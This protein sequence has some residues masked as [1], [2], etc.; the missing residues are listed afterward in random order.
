MRVAVIV[1]FVL[2]LFAG[3]CKK[4]TTPAR[5]YCYK[6]DQKFWRYPANGTP[7]DSM[8]F[9]DTSSVTCNDVNLGDSNGCGFITD[10]TKIGDYYIKGY[11]CLRLVR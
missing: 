6:V 5:Q 10:W 4:T 9:I 8:Y 2:I 11:Q 1:C 3:G 7:S